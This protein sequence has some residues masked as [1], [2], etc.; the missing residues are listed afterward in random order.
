V[1]PLADSCDIL[2]S[3]RSSRP[4]EPTAIDLESRLGATY[5]GNGR[6]QFLVWAPRAKRV[7]VKILGPNEQ[8]IP[9]EPTEKGY[10]QLT[11]TDAGPGTSYLFR[12]DNQKERPDPA[13][14]YQPF[15]V[16][17]PSQIT[18]PHAFRWN[19]ANWSGLD[20]EKY[21]LYELHVGTFTAEG[22]FDAILPRLDEIK[23]LGITA[24]EL[25]PVAQFPGERNWGYDGVYPF[26]VQ[27]SYGGPEGLKRLVDACHQREMAVVLDVVYNHLGPEGN[28]LS[29]Y[30]PYFTDAYRTPWGEA[31][32]F[33]GP[34]S[35]EVVKFFVQNALY[36]LEDIHIDALRL[37]AI[38]GIVDRNARPFLGLLAAEAE[39]Y[40]QRTGRKV[41]LIAES[42]LNDARFV[43]PQTNNGYGLDAQWNDDFHHAVHVLMT[44]EQR[45][46]Y[47]DFGGIG[48]L[49]KAFTEGYVYTG[50]Y[51]KFRK[52]R[53]GNSPREIAARQ[54]VVFTQNHDQVGNRMLGERLS[55]L[56]S[57]EGLKLCAG[58]LVLSPFLPLI[59][60]GE[61]YGEN[62]PFLYFT[63][64]SD[65]NL[66]DAVR[67]GRKE[68][69]AAFA[70]QGEPP[71][72]QDEST[73][74]KSKLHH[75]RT[76]QE[77]HRTLREFYKKLLELRSS[78][79]ALRHLSKETTGVQAYE[80]EK[81]LLVTRST[82]QTHVFMAFNLGD[83]DVSVNCSAA[84]G[85][86]EKLVESSDQRWKGP[87][88]ILPEALVSEDN[89]ELTLRSKS[90]CLFSVR[91]SPE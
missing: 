34:R 25:M 68:E 54:L 58:L 73:F 26:A 11:A 35:D 33:D 77:P 13:S 12:L 90:F 22:T 37:D 63:S 16:H 61:E 3:Q 5:L 42:D 20:L 66:I 57:F 81:A 29:D 67:R 17:K 59:F 32:N 65:P 74:L 72:P 48:Q 27:A 53:H 85:T 31:I 55:Q 2:P 6:C 39:G 24:V 78:L 15:G 38:H 10:H 41:F 91:R 7:E 14:R 88:S 47:E 30:G 49:A 60:M 86:W 69:F 19:D 50:E 18:D 51:S 1:N 28:Y 71:D 46:Y 23:S 75:D 36:W 9:L 87:G 84:K 76:Q 83:H 56:V 43:L 80:E 70:W 8:S 62:A 44:G 82:D 64:H 21:V 45:G 52:R 4:I 40:R 89:I 79:P